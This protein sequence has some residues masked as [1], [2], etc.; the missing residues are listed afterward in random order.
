[1]VFGR[2]PFPRGSWMNC[3]N[4]MSKWSR[5]RR[6]PL[7]AATPNPGLPIWTL[8]GRP[9]QPRAGSAQGGVAR[10]QGRHRDEPK[11]FRKA[12]RGAVRCRS[13]ANSSPVPAPG[14][15]LQKAREFFIPNS[16]MEPCRPSTA[17]SSP[18]ISI[19]PAG[20]W[21]WKVLFRPARLSYQRGGL[22]AFFNRVHHIPGGAST[23]SHCHTG[24]RNRS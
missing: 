16:A 20:R 19:R 4:R 5:L 12:G 13:R 22:Y 8:T 14:L 11:L 3:R 7:M 24:G 1:M 10:R 17:T 2:R 23:C 15:P 21:F 9:M 18:S 6:V